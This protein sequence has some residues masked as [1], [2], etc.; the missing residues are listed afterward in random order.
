MGYPLPYTLDFS[1]SAN[2]NI[3]RPTLLVHAVFSLQQHG[4]YLMLLSHTL[5]QLER[6]RSG[7]PGFLWR[8]TARLVLAGC[9]KKLS[10]NMQVFAI[11]IQNIFWI[12][13]FF[14]FLTLT[15]LLEVCKGENVKVPEPFGFSHSSLFLWLYL[16]ICLINYKAFW[17]GN[18]IYREIYISRGKWEYF[19]WWQ[20]KYTVIGHG[21]IRENKNIVWSF[22]PK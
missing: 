5:Q 1:S 3:P 18:S 4:K 11:K 10:E 7:G 15:N 17:F 9:Y 19:H 6:F 20:G 13:F 21:K 16:H 14:C 22:G 12:F 8:T 2:K